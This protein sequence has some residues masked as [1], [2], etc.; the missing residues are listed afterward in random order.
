[1]LLLPTFGAL[2]PSELP[3]LL[4]K[5]VVMNDAASA[6]RVAITD[7]G[8]THLVIH[9]VFYEPPRD[10]RA[11]EQRVNA[12]E[13]IFLLN[14][15]EDDFVRGTLAPLPSPL[16][17]ITLQPIAKVLRVELVEDFPQIEMPPLLRKSELPLHRQLRVCD[18][19]FLRGHGATQNSTSFGPS[20][21]P[22]V[23]KNYSTGGNAFPNSRA[24]CSKRFRRSK[25]RG[26]RAMRANCVFCSLIG[27]AG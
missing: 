8:V 10:E 25:R 15:R 17:A 14:R 22:L 23:G 20:S 13:P 5:F 6:R 3:L 24:I 7:N 18:F 12:D 19:A 1:M 26:S 21:K 11:I 4:V 27:I 9:H 2:E 16:D